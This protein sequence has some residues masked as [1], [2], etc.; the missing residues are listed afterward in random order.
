MLYYA[1]HCGTFTNLTSKIEEGVQRKTNALHLLVDSFLIC[2]ART[3]A[4]DGN[5][6][7]LHQQNDIQLQNYN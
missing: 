5:V 2:Q 4:K 3:K 6:V 7:E 1:S